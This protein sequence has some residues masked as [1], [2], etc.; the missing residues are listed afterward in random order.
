MTRR[1]AVAAL[2]LAW[3]LIVPGVGAAP[4][5]RVPTS[6]PGDARTYRSALGNAS[7]AESIDAIRA[8]VDDAGQVAPDVVPH[9]V[10]LGGS[11]GE[12]LAELWPT[13]RD[14][15]RAGNAT[16]ARSLAGAAVDVLDDTLVDRA[17]A[18]GRNRT[19][20]TPGRTSGTR[21]PIVLL[22]PPPSGLGAFEI[23]VSADDPVAPT[24]ATVAVGQ[25]QTSLDPDN[26]SAALASFDARALAG[27]GGASQ[28]AV[29]LGHVTFP[30]GAGTIPVEVEVV[31]LVDPD[32][33]S[34]PA[35]SPTGE[36]KVASADLL[37]V[38][39]NAL[40]LVLVAGLG[41][42]AIVA[43]RRVVRL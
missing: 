28:Q 8:A 25:G 6:L 30:S 20:I 24:G 38:P 7:Q 12:L 3:L 14:E 29:T 31:E 19:T 37:E 27:L 23:R 2:A 13:L 39:T 18:W 17:D 33:R 9:L 15:A 16:N 26:G 43:V 41:I 32:G 1:T 40:A 11:D 5:D 35:V 42:V 4:I 21:V 34:V 10:D 36:I 22:H